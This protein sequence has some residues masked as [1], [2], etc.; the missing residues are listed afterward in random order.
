MRGHVDTFR[1]FMAN[2]FLTAENDFSSH[3]YIQIFTHSNY[4]VLK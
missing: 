2:L 1:P 3:F 4:I